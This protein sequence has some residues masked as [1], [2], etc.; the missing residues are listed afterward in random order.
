MPPP[1]LPAPRYE[2][3]SKDVSKWRPLVKANAAAPTIHFTSD[4]AAVHTTTTVA[5]LVDKHAPMTGMEAEVAAM[6]ARA[7][8]HSDRALAESEQALAARVRGAA[9]VVPDYGGVGRL[10][11]GPGKMPGPLTDPYIPTEPPHRS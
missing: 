8:A 2:A 6:L 11:C 3:A 10:G 4:K 1:T 7:G 5:G 9:V